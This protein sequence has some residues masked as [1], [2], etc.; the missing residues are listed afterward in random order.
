V[1]DID[2]L[3]SNVSGAIQLTLS[4]VGA[5]IRGVAVLAL[6]VGSATFATGWWVFD[7]SSTWLVIGGALCLLPPIAAL[8][9]WL[10]VARTARHAPQLVRDVRALL[11][12]TRNSAAVL[13][14][15]DTGQSLVVASKSFRAL[16][17]ELN[18]R[19]KELP[20]LFAGVR[21]ITSAPGLAAIAVLGVLLLG[22]L[23]TILLIGGL[24][25]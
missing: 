13:I 25:D 19:R 23:G 8:R 21:A 9:G 11:Q 2:R 20:T 14:D 17:I 7:H 3:T 22:G 12:T 4:R 5:L 16:R 10:M 15:H 1:A 18:E 6:L 24:I